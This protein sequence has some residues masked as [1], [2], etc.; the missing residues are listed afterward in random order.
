MALAT[1]T[2]MNVTAAKLQN[3]LFTSAPTGFLPLAL[4]ARSK[5]TF[6]IESSYALVPLEIK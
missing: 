5:R 3:M 1:E 6:S 4:P 2:A